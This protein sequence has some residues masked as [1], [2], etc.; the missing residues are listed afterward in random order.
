VHPA[1]RIIK[2]PVKNSNDVP[3]TEPIDAIGKA[4]GAAIN[5]EN[6]QGKYK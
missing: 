1:P 3:T 4:I 5:V 6:K 2:A